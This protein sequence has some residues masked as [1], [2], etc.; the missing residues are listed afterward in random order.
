[1]GSRQGR[2]GVARACQEELDPCLGSTR[3]LVS[4]LYPRQ[5]ALVHPFSSSAMGT[6]GSKHFHAMHKAKWAL[7]TRGSPAP[8]SGRGALGTDSE[9]GGQSAGIHGLG[10]CYRVKETMLPV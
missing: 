1:M 9:K 8:H 3:A 4:L 6:V 5:L 10:T 2:E 7:K